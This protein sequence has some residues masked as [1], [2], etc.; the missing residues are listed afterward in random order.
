MSLAMLL[1]GGVDSSVALHLLLRGEVA[2]LGAVSPRDV[3]AVYLKI[4]LEDELSY[5]GH[6]PWEDD[7]SVVRE[8]CRR[9]GVRLEVLS[10][11]RSYRDLVIETALAE[12]RAGR[13]PSP[14]ILCNRRI[15]FGAAMRRLEELED[16]GGGGITRLASGHYAR[17]RLGSDGLAELWRG[18]DPVKDQSYFLYRLEQRQLARCLFPLGE[19]HKHEVRALAG[20]LSLPNQRRPDSQGLCFLGGV[21]F[22][23]FVRAHLGEEPGPIRRL[24][25]GDVLGEHRGHWF[26]TVGQRKGLGLGGGPWFVVRKEVQTRTLWVVHGSQIERHRARGLSLGS[27]HWISGRA[28]EED[29]QHVKLR[30]GPA[31]LAASAERKPGGLDLRLEQ[32]DAAAPGQAAIL[33][34]GERCLGGGWIEP[35]TSP[36]ALG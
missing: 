14:D 6:C 33:Y 2:E 35:E 28:A 15:K 1:S 30:H 24:D 10:L 17:Q 4:W 36:E 19:L 31:L 21:D 32:P 23:D 27:I 5:L 11:Q 18:V 34:R 12:L 9:A 16:G 22:N 26:Y 8:V 3:T 20:E 25:S 29:V 13:T 7:L